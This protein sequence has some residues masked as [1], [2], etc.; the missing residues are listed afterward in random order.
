MSYKTF[1]FRAYATK[2][3]YTRIDR[4]LHLSANL[5]NAALEERV[6]AY[7]NKGLSISRF[8]QFKSLTQVRRD[9]PENFGSV[10]TAVF[11]GPLVRLDRAMKRFFERVKM[12]K[13]PAFRGLSPVADGIPWS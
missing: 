2:A 7:R 4:L 3:G 1:Q 9:D 12:V 5:Y 8:D 6:S 13:N 11:R 10:E